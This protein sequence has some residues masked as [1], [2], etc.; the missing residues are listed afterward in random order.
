MITVRRIAS[1]AELPMPELIEGS[2]PKMDAGTYDWG[3][4]TDPA[5][6][7]VR[8]AN[9]AEALVS[10]PQGFVFSF[11]IDGEI[12]LAIF[13]T[14][15]DDGDLYSNITLARPYRGS[16]SY[17]YREDIRAARDAF[18]REQGVKRLLGFM[19]PGS[20]LREGMEVRNGISPDYELL[21]HP[22]AAGQSLFVAWQNTPG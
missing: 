22:H 19:P 6:K 9:F 5:E 3:R 2:I 12:V 13:G 11:D 4:T 18:L 1:C 10:D 21:T 14:L 7:T 17:I 8:L 16:R 15:R 20:T